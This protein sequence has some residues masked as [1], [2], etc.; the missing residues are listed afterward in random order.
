M[1]VPL[2]IVFSYLSIAVWAGGYQGCLERVW[3][4]QA[5]QIDGLNDPKDQT[6]GMKC[7]SWDRTKKECTGG[8]WTPCKPKKNSGRTRCNFDDL[9]I[10]LGGANQNLQWTVNDASGNLDTEKTAAQCYDNHVKEGKAVKSPPPYTGWLKDTWEYNDYI[11]KLGK[12]A[13]DTAKNKRTDENKHLWA[14]F[15]DTRDK[16]LTART[17]DHGPFLIR[18][19]ERRLGSKMQIYKEDLGKSPGTGEKWETVDWAETFK[20]ASLRNVKNPGREI[21]N[22]VK[23]WYHGPMKSKSASDHLQVMKSYETVADR[24]WTCR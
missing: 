18:E 17:G 21:A 10:H 19:A 11:T 20:Q 23:D 5:Y 1:R 8:N 9:I 13:D 24:A 7:R 2:F 6:V 22:F 15:D 16:I 12:V 14:G 3:L 4:Y